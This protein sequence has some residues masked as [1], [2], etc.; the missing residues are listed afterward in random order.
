MKEYRIVCTR[1]T[2]CT[3][4]EEHISENVAPWVSPSSLPH[5]EVYKTKAD[6]MKA[7][8][9]TVRSARAFDAKTQKDLADGVPY[10]IGYWQSDIR[11]QSRTVTEWKN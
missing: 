11:L 1:K 2:V 5:F 7:L 9:K 3:D 10:S 6:A 8:S 4:G